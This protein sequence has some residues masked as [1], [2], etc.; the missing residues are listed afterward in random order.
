MVQLNRIILAL[1]FMTATL[2]QSISVRS[3]GDKDIC[4]RKYFENEDEMNFSFIISGEDELSFDIIIRDNS[5][6]I[7]YSKI[8]S[9]NDSFKR[10]LTESG[11]YELC[12]KPTSRADNDISFNWFG[13]NE[14]G[15]L[16][17]IAKGEELS[18]MQTDVL[19]LRGLFEQIEINIKYIIERQQKHSESKYYNVTLNSHYKFYG[20]FEILCSI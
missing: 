9:D 18:L 3:E 16:F 12:F 10:K 5:T 15:H 17:N 7:L 8:Q 11:E 2:V 19:S 1:V 20:K 13:L 14:K 4:F 6:N